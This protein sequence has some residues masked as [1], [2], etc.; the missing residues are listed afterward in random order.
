[1]EDRSIDVNKYRFIVMLV[2]SMMLATVV[3]Y[4]LDNQDRLFRRV[5]ELT[6]KISL[7][8]HAMINLSGRQNHANG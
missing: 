4:L 3:L 8:D 7:I 6:E 5:Q 2:A 1:M